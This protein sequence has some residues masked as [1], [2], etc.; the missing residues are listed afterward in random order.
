[1]EMVPDQQVARDRLHPLEAQDY[2]VPC[3]RFDDEVPRVNRQEISS[4][5]RRD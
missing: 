2:A 4:G 5:C 1:M 3:L